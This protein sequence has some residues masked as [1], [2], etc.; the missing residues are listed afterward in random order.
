MSSIVD[1]GSFA[2]PLRARL[3]PTKPAPT[4][5]TNAVAAVWTCGRPKAFQLVSLLD[6]VFCHWLLCRLRR[7]SVPC[8]LADNRVLYSTE[9]LSG[10]LHLLITHYF[11]FAA[12]FKRYA[13]RVG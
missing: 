11:Y 13:Y 12:Y 4:S 10:Q 6:C 7:R 1:R 5:L 8:S 3:M 2:V 9:P